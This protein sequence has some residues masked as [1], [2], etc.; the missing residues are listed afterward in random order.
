MNMSR[1]VVSVLIM[2]VYSAPVLI[3]LGLFGHWLA[4]AAGA[5]MTVGL[6]IF[7]LILGLSPKRRL[8]SEG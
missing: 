2:S 5:A 6:F 7:A 3:L 8:A 1:Y 4:G